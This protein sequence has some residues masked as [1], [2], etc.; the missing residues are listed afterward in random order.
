VGGGMELF[1]FVSVFFGIQRKSRCWRVFQP[2][3]V[4]L[5]KK[6]KTKF[7]GSHHP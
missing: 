5:L 2:I 4:F 6:D 7:A 3:L 1:S